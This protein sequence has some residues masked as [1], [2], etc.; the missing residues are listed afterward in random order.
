[1][2]EHKPPQVLELDDCVVSED[3]C[4]VAFFAHDSNA[5]VGSLYHIDIVES[6]TDAK[7]Q[8]VPQFHLD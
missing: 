5:N 8:L 4:L 7:Y 1:M 6:I 2:P 3:R